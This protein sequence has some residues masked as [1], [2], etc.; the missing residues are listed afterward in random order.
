MNEER[1]KWVN[2][3]L[4][5]IQASQCS[6]DKH[7]LA[8][9]WAVD[10]SKTE[11]ELCFVKFTL[12]NRKHHCRKCGSIVCH[13][14]SA[15]KTLLNH[16]DANN[17]VRICDN[18]FVYKVGTLDMGIG[19]EDGDSNDYT[20]DLNRLV[21]KSTDHTSPPSTKDKNDSFSGRSGGNSK[22]LSSNFSPST[23]ANRSSTSSRYR[24]SLNN[25]EVKD[26]QAARRGTSKGGCLSYYLLC[27]CF[28]ENEGGG[29]RSS[30]YTD[31]LLTR[32]SNNQGTS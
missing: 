7:G 14:C 5:A 15:H 24:D 10:S 6:V 11:C 23:N 2:A 1:N 4:A 25:A 21:N 31:P 22:H 3:I 32:D 9:V 16:V 30:T 26:I 28:C 13:E 20:V 17:E 19:T 12:L 18:C 29:E 27:G 8:P